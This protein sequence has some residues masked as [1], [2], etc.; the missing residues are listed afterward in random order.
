M[1]QFFFLVV[2]LRSAKHLAKPLGRCE[3]V[4]GPDFLF[5]FQF[6]SGMVLPGCDGTQDVIA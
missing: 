5:Q 3:P 6:V 2:M 4:T 1:T